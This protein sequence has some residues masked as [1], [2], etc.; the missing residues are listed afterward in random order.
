MSRFAHANLRE[1]AHLA[2]AAPPR[3][4]P[5]LHPRSTGRTRTYSAESGYVY[6]YSFAGFRR[7]RRSG[8]LHV[9]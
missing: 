3:A 9:E 8:E 4:A 2:Q 7:I 1:S 6:E 5:D